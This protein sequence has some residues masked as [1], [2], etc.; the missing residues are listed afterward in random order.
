[1]EKDASNSFNLGNGNGYSVR[2]IIQTIKRISK[3]DFKVIESDRRPGDPP[4]LICN[5][6][7][8]FDVLGWRPHYGDIDSIVETAFRWHSKNI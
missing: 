1:M 4:V 5:Y 7:K 6:K 8:A 2:D 3:K